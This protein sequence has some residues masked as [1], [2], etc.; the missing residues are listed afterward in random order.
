[1]KNH[2]LHAA[3]VAT[4]TTTAGLALAEAPFS[5][6][7]TP[8]KLPKD[9]LPVQYL[10]H[11]VPDIEANTFRGDETVEIEVRKQ[12]STLM[13][14]ADN[15]DIDA[16]TL[17]GKG[18]SILKLVPSVDR[19]QQTVTF[20]LAQP[21]QPGRYKLAL[22]F[23]GLIN[24]EPRGM[25]HMNYK[26]AGAD[27]KMIGTTM[28][29]S[30]AR[31]LLPSW[32]E[33]SFRAKFKLSIDVPATFSA[34]SNTPV[35]KQQALPDGKK[36]VS[37]AA[38]PKMPSYLVV[39]VAGELERVAAKQDGV[40][41]GVVTT[42]GKQESATLPLADAKQVLHYYNNYFGVPYPLPKLDL[43]AVPGGFNGAMENWGGIV[44]NE[45]AL[46]VDPKRSPVPVKKGTFMVNSHEIA[47]QWFGNLVT[48]AWWDNLWLNEGFASWMSTKAM[49]H[50]H[51]EWRPYL[52][53]IAEREYVLNLDARKTT[54]PIQTRI[55]N[56]A[57][58]ANAFDAITYQKGEAFLRM[59][60]A[61]LG[62]DS[63]RRGIRSYMAKHQYS[64]TTSQDLWNALEAASGKPVGK[65]ASDWTLQAGFPLVKVEQACVDGKR[66]VT[67]SQE[68]FRLD[69]P[70]TD[71]RVWNVPVQVGTVNGKAGY[72]LLSTPSATVTQANCDGALVVDPY[73]VGFF[74][75]QYD[76]QSFQALAAQA[77][78]LPDPT[79]LKLLTD[80]WAMV[81]DGR[82][83]LDSYLNLVS[84]YRDE[85]RLAVWESI[86]GNLGNLYQLS[87]GEPQQALI[88][89]FIIG[90]A[91]PKFRELGW[92]EKQGEPTEDK[93][94][95]ALLATALAR[96]GDEEAIREAKTR[97]ARYLEDPSSVSPS[98]LDFVIGTAGRYADAATYDALTRRAL[99]TTSG[100][101]RNRFGR[102]LMSAQ[103]PAL[104]ARTLQLALSPQLPPH[105]A[106]VIVPGVAREH[107]DL[108]WKF[109]VDHRDQLLKNLDAMSS[110]RA[111]AEVVSASNRAADADMMENY[112]RQ[113]FGPDALVEAQRVGNGVRIRAAQKAR[114]LPQAGAALK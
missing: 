70:A 65:L 105:L 17:S 79:R 31:R 10:A 47:H 112:V 37:F 59:L 109:A 33:P 57:Q 85:Q 104:A 90:F 106:S 72:T 110:N 6:D 32:D 30:D 55:D 77:P 45:A 98:M 64:N 83:Q 16:A 21:L 111:F 114:L 69:E 92:D 68:V 89:K 84:Q 8:G 56:E 2:L 39:L 46:L 22:Q 58:A 9:V 27:K 52:D 12:T 1:M 18:I 40:E 36:R 20:N 88:G 19:Q 107:L 50:F 5:F 96:A 54:H 94:L 48:M 82:M 14:N 60:E 35:D 91:K 93:R 38:T 86:A 49:D 99:E 87:R 44:Y 53:A 71:K 74:R 101:E 113:N 67:L 15:L 97:F 3:V 80:T 75:V 63:F 102:A 62:E 42:A 81:S 11:I 41:I 100:E 24:R 61:Y 103:D 51:P 66:R 73:S 23:R 7:A 25:F 43:I 13:L 95:R 29:P 108:A 26:V 76:P 78:K 28:E 34:Y 4:L